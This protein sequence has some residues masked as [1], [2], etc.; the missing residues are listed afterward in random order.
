MSDGRTGRVRSTVLPVVLVAFVVIGAQLVVELS[1]PT[2]RAERDVALAS[3]PE[4]TIRLVGAGV[5]S[6]A[7]LLLARGLVRDRVAIVAPDDHLASRYLAASG[8]AMLACTFTGAVPGAVVASAVFLAVPLL[9]RHHADPNGEAHRDGLTAA[10]VALGASFA[11]LVGRQSFGTYQRWS[12]GYG[13]SERQ[14]DA[15][16]ADHH[17]T[18]LVL[19]LQVVAV[20][21]ALL[22][23]Y[24][25]WRHR[26]R[27]GS[28]SE[29]NFYLKVP[30]AVVT[31]G[32]IAFNPP[33]LVI[34]LLCF[35]LVLVLANRADQPFEPPAIS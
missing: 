23:P 2:E 20:V 35:P 22:V 15:Y 16:I 14:L 12:D 26:R 28:A 27:L 29:R 1:L 4:W 24:V 6:L 32:V 21:G 33:V 17:G 3:G 13:A 7:T 19:V 25:I 31:A 34:G 9:R 18:V 5:L 30:L 10:F 8:F 11:L